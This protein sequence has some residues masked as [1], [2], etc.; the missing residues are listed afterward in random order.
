MGNRTVKWTRIV[1][2]SCEFKKQKQ[3]TLLIE[4]LKGLADINSETENETFI[5]ITRHIEINENTDEVN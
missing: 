5:I 4:G 1:S 2:L 3:H